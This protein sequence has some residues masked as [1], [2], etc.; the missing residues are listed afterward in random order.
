MVN[1]NIIETDHSWIL[2]RNDKLLEIFIHRKYLT[3]RAIYDSLISFMALHESTLEVDFIKNMPIFESAFYLWS[4]FHGQPFSNVKWNSLQYDFENS[5][6]FS[7]DEFVKIMHVAQHGPGKAL[8]PFYSNPFEPSLLSMD[9]HQCYTSTL[10]NNNLGIGSKNALTF[11]L[12]TR[13][14]RFAEGG[15][16]PQV[17]IMIHQPDT[18]PDFRSR[19]NNFI[20]LKS[21][22]YSF[23]VKATQ[24]QT[25][26]SFDAMTL[27][28][29]KCNN[30]PGY[31]A[32]ACLQHHEIQL[33]I[34]KC[35]CIPWYFHETK[36]SNVCQLENATCFRKTQEKLPEENFRITGDCIPECGYVQYSTSVS[37]EE[38]VDLAE[39]YLESKDYAFDTANI[40]TEMEYQDISQAFTKVQVYFESPIVTVIT[41]DAKVTFPDM[42]GNIGGTLGVFLGLSIVGLM[43]EIVELVQFFKRSFTNSTTSQ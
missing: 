41:K 4:Y 23:G 19:F 14:A 6:N 24:V 10:R 11:L 7:Q 3:K 12:S 37:R 22:F 13:M 17:K 33:A 27:A 25:T 15:K 1:E 20:E 2:P 35:G 29:R 5:L 43:D 28:K 39:Y 38:N 40:L 42:L 30:S 9:D 8:I 18:P 26:Q 36:V 32:S 31:S 16:I 21:G 34:E